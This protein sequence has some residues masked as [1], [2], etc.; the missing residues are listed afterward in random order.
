M[1]LHT[2]RSKTQAMDIKFWRSS[3]GKTRYIAL[4]MKL[5][6]MLEFRNYCE[7]QK[8]NDCKGWATKKK[9][10]NVNAKKGISRP[11]SV[12]YKA[13]SQL[14][15]LGATMENKILHLRNLLLFFKKMDKRSIH[16]QIAAFLSYSGII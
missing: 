5:L 3:E 2:E 9:G 6:N 7:S 8:K 10:Q 13:R 1:S 4:G 15:E 11:A 14:Y 12:S 16:I